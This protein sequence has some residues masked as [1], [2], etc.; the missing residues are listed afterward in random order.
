MWTVR[1][2]WG[3]KRI[4]ELER[5]IKAA[6]I[7]PH[8][9]DLCRAYGRIKSACLDAGIVVPAN[10]LWIATCAVRHMIPLV[11][12]NSKHFEG[13]PGLSVITEANKPLPAKTGDLF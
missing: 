10:D 5:H 11:T 2:K 13:I 9:Q 1:K 12:H 8:D 6:V 7:V 3:L 4:A